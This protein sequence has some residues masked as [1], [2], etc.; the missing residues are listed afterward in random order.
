MQNSKKTI[1]ANEINKYIYCP[2][3][4][5]YER[6]YGKKYIREKHKQR[7]SELNLKNTTES[8]FV[9]GQKFHNEYLQK[10]KLKKRLRLVFFIIII[11]LMLSV[12]YYFNVFN[13]S[14]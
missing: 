4:W 11:L 6:Y 9:K 7:I 1:T 12:Y 8:N 5:Y 10:D 13:I 3:Q 2:Y 14:G